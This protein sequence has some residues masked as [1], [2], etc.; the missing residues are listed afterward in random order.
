[1]VRWRSSHLIFVVIKDVKYS[2]SESV[3]VPVAVSV[4]FQHLDF[5]V[6]ALCKAICIAA[7]K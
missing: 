2:V 5:V 6:A 4:S 7:V 1:M 3:K